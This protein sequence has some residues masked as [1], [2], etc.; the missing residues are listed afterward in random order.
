MTDAV[1]NKKR[2]FR[3]RRNER[4]RVQIPI[5]IILSVAITFTLVP[6]I[7]T[8]INSLKANIEVQKSIFTL[9]A[10]NSVMWSNYVKAFDYVGANIWNSV[11]I[12]FVQS[13]VLVVI[14]AV[15]AYI[16]AEIKFFGSNLIFYVY[17]M[18]MVLPGELNTPQNYA[19]IYKAN[20]LNSYWAVWLPGWASAQASGIFLFRIFFMGQPKSLK[21]AARIDGASNFQLFSRI[22]LPITIPIVIYRFLTGFTAS[23]NSYLWNT[24]VLQ[25]QSK[26]SVI[27]LLMLKSGVVKDNA[28]QGYG[29]LYAMYIISGLPLMAVSAVSLKFFKGTEFASA[30]KM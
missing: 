6:F 17:I 18:V 23:Y 22:V 12:A 15:M 28:R 26:M 7:L 16:F 30:L 27:T 21:E 13:A 4:L 8:L 11:F 24:L 29:V 3:L 5:I 20:L 10:P 19:F 14:S 2:T 9:P 25:D 1:R